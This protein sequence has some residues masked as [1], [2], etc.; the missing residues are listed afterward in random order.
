MRLSRI[1]SDL[2]DLSRLEGGSDRAEHVRLDVIAADEVER[3]G[4]SAEEAGVA[5][6]NSCGIPSTRVEI[7]TASPVSGDSPPS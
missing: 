3:L 2:L 1:V 6:K 5:W 4:D 7:T